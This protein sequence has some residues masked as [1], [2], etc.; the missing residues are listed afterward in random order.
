MQ[1]DLVETNGDHDAAI[2]LLMEQKAS[3]IQREAFL[4]A[5]D[6]KK[7]IAALREDKERKEVQVRTVGQ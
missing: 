4:D 7:R 2:L 1:L 6:L 5:E 3:A